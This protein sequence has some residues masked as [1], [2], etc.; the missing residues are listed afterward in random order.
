MIVIEGHVD[1]TGWYSLEDQFPLY[2]VTAITHRSNPIYLTT[3]VGKPPQEDYQARRG[4]LECGDLSPLFFPPT[5]RR[6][7]TGDKSPQCKAATSRREAKAMTSHRT[8]KCDIDATRELRDFL[9]RWWSRRN[10]ASGFTC[11]ATK[12]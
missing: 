6:L 2:H 9:T 11:S 5:C 1:P 3:I 10:D 7:R 12:A 8:P 4:D